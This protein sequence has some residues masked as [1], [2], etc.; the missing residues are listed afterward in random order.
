VATAQ[1]SPP[2]HA[3]RAQRVNRPAWPRG[4]LHRR[5]GDVTGQQR[6]RR[7]P[8]A[9]RPAQAH[10]SS[11]PDVSVSV[12]WR[13]MYLR[14][15]I[16]LSTRHRTRPRRTLR[17]LQCLRAPPF[18]Y[19]LLNST[20][21]SPPS[22]LHRAPTRYAPSPFP[23]CAAPAPLRISASSA[24]PSAPPPCATSSANHH[25]A[26][27]RHLGPRLPASSRRVGGCVLAQRPAGAEPA[28]TTPLRVSAPQAHLTRAPPVLLLPVQVDRRPGAARHGWA[29]AGC[30]G[31]LR[32]SASQLGPA[33]GQLLA[34]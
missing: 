8:V 9:A 7:S 13:A 15:R 23:A 12:A 27:A 14:P 33:R 19:I 6:A 16:V 28:G 17:L 31:P 25:P 5:D 22:C 3:S 1:A 32:A 20:S 26:T 24:A 34:V 2:S 11:T 10:A 29:W 18:D 4:T 30:G 21:Y